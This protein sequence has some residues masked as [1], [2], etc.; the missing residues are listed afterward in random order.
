MPDSARPLRVGV[1]VFFPGGGIGRYTH[2]LMTALARHEAVAVE[3]LCTPEYA[4]ASAEAYATW[5]GLARISHRIPALRRWRFLK[6]QFVNPK[7]ALEH[8]RTAGLDVLHLAHINHLSFPYW[9][10]RA[11]RVGVPV[12]ASAHDVTRGKRIL[13]R[14]WE[15]RQ[16]RAFYRWA[17]ALF[18][19]SAHQVHELEAFAE[20]AP[21]AVHV[22]PHGPYT[23]G[24]VSAS[25]AA[26]RR[27]WDLPAE[28]PVALM[29]GKLRDGKNLEGLLRALA[30]TDAS[31][32]LVVAGAEDDRHRGAA[33]YRRLADDLGLGASVRIRPGRLEDPA[34]GELFVAADWV[35]LPYSASFTSQSGVLNV[36]AH[37]ERPV[38]VS[39]APVLHETVTACD[40]GVACSGDT[41]AALARGIERLH[42]RLATG[43]P[44]AFA[45]YRDRF[46]WRENASRTVSVYRSLLA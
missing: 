33:H 2:R 46:S 14:M 21:E 37:Y 17:D 15:T 5:P 38:L 19:H 7:R 23:H 16:L 13:S 18:V 12:V 4:W 27:Q 10:R 42:R 35:A 26:L 1:Y 9:R 3:A 41:P 20:V 43:H 11:E 6:G 36:A 34:V 8:A 44:H 40:I 29:F 31:P 45:A 28:R 25:K 32:Y 22:V 24:T 30:R 39:S